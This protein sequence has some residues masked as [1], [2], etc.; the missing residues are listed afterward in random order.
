MSVPKLSLIISVYKDVLAL[1]LILR[2]VQRQSYIGELEVIIAEDCEGKEIQAHINEWRRKYPFSIIHIHQADIGFRKC[3]I[4]NE[5]IRKASSDYLLF[6]DG[7]CILHKQLVKEHLLASKKG[8]VVYG[9]RVML[10]EFLTKQFLATKNFYLLNFLMLFITG[11]NRLDAALYLPF[12][13]PKIKIGF[14]GHN[15][16][17]YKDDIKLV[18]GFD[19]AYEQAG[20]GEDTDIEWRLQQKG[21][22]FLRIKNKAIQ[23][24]LFH[25]SHYAS[26]KAVENLLIQKKQKYLAGDSTVLMGSL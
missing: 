2:S 20:I 4:L 14:W 12:T 7:D 3:K 22:Q 21:I 13:K 26:T 6:I 9:R 8:H 24:H 18:G 16:S 10:S 15:W 25:T 17:I 19:E 5:A 11:C 23:Y 1:D